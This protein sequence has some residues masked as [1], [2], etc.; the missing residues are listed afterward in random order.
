M[1]KLLVFGY[2][3]PSRGDDA[4]G[5]MAVDQLSEWQIRHRWNHLHLLTDYQLQIE[6]ITDLEDQD[7]VVFIDADICCA[8]PFV[9]NTC[10]ALN[11]QSYTSHALSPQA[12]LGIYRHVHNEDPPPSYLIQ[13][14]GEQFELGEPLSIAA[15]SNL[16]AT[17][18]FI[19]QLCRYPVR[20]YAQSCCSNALRI[21]L[22]A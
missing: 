4:L 16:A 12:L 22:D 21:P 2:G 15:K 14:R 6:H 13:I 3:N 18:T 8:P 5:P 20:G 7:L 10:A 19:H 9:V 11:D 17:L 1:D